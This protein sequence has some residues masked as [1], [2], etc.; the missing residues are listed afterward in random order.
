MA[1]FRWIGRDEHSEGTLRKEER[2]EK[3]S[4]CVAGEFVERE[5][6]VGC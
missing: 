1:G 4:E 5:W 6:R 2:K 3:E